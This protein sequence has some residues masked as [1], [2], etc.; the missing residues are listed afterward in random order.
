M[1]E[2]RIRRSAEKEIRALPQEARARVVPAI[3]ELAQIPR[4]QGCQKLS[5]RDAWRIGVGRYRVVYTIEDQ[6]LLIEIV[7]VAHRRDVYR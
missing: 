1:Y 2:L 5:G 7:K 4:P 6:C 3:L